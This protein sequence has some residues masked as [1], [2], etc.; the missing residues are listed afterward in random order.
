MT[1][2]RQ[3]PPRLT[4]ANSVFLDFLR[5]V[6]AQLV[7]IGHGISLFGVLPG[8][9]PPF[10]PWIQSFAV[11][12]F[13]WLSGFLISHSVQTRRTDPGYRFRDFFIDRFARIYSG[14]VPAIAIV[15]I[16]DLVFLAIDADAYRFGRHFD[17]PTAIQ[18]LFMLQ[19]FPV[20]LIGTSL[21]GSGS[22]W[23]TLG[24]EWW[25]YMFFGWLMLAVMPR[26]TDRKRL[27]VLLLL[28]A[29]PIGYT[30]DG[31]GY[32]GHGL[33]L[34]WL[35]AALMPGFVTMVCD[36]FSAG[37]SGLLGLLMLA[38][39]LVRLKISGDAFDMIASILFGLAMF[40]AIARFQQRAGP[41]LSRLERP[42]RLIAGY[43]F[44]LFL[45]HYSIVLLIDL[46]VPGG[47]W[48]PFAIS[49]LT[50]NIIA[51]IVALPTEMQH[52]H[53][54]RWLQ[55]RFGSAGARGPT[56]AGT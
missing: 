16:A 43:G 29:V 18:N 19:K 7:L 13:F 17:V 20:G 55:D 56:G 11:V 40:F 9:H 37:A 4:P 54:A 15:T 6:L 21:F 44:T 23:W 53:V 30:I 46:L 8:L 33:A 32:V 36:R 2:P 3:T 12:G 48:G 26:P 41:L 1:L 39:C 34:M 49:L 10:F 45:T 31:T 42:V 38:L 5:A 52:R 47:G 35:L 50:A 22:T 27:L 24:I 14:F 28:S 51:L 25:I